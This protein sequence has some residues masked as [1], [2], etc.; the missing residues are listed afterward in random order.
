M[1]SSWTPFLRV[2]QRVLC[3]CLIQLEVFAN[4][5]DFVGAP[6]D[7]ESRLGRGI[8]RIRRARPVSLQIQEISRRWRGRDAR[9]ARVAGSGSAEIGRKDN[10]AVIASA[11]CRQGYRGA[12]TAEHTDRG[13][14]LTGH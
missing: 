8:L 11:W 6:V 2:P 7:P 9:D 13:A 1:S 14:R 3:N 12:S 5:N 10:A 4:E